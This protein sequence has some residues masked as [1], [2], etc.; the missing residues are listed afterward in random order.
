[1]AVAYEWR[2]RVGDEEL[3]ALHAAAFGHAFEPEAWNPRL[4]RHSLGWVT[5]RDGET[6]VGFVNVVSDGRRH[7][8]L[9]DT[10]VAPDLQGRGIGKEL[11]AEAIRASRDAGADWLHVDFEPRLEAFYFS[12]GFRA[13]AAGVL[14]LPVGGAS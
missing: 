10:A 13:T 14:D 2:G 4:E 6:L 12:A 8:F 7:G 3:S 11:V 9:V 1:M 5:A